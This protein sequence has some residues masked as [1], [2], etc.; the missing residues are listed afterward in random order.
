MGANITLQ[1]VPHSERNAGKPVHDN[2]GA[3][4]TVRAQCAMCNAFR[5]RGPRPDGV[6]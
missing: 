5:P 3:Y 1:A 2:H 4:H 6:P